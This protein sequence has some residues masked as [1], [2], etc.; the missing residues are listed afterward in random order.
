MNRVRSI[1]TQELVTNLRRRSYLLITFGVPV[2]AI[3]LV[4]AILL[5]RGDR[6]DQPDDPFA[7]LPAQPIGYVD[8]TGRFPDPGPY[9]TILVPYPD[10]AS[11][12]AAVQAGELAGYYLIPADYLATGDVTRFS[13]QFSVIETDTALFQSFLVTGL[14]RDEDP[15]LL[16]RLQQPA[17]I[18]EHQLD[19]A[20]QPVTQI[21]GR[22][23]DNFWPIYAFALVL[24][25]STFFSSGQ[26]TR[27]VVVEKENRMIEVVLS[28]LRPLQILAGKMV[29]QGIAGLI[30]VLAWLGAILLIIHIT[31]ADI[32]FLGPVDIPFS[33]FIIA[34]L[35]YLGG[36]SLFAAFAAGIGAISTNMRE[37][38]Q[39]AIVYTLPAVI[40]MM[41]LPIITESPNG[42]F[43]VVLSL[44]PF[45]SPLGMIARLVITTV[46]A[47]QIALSLALLFLGVL[48][49]LW[50]SAR[51]F[52]VNT[53][54]SGQFPT[55]RQLVQLLIRG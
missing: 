24:L 18:V 46:P 43:A 52:R 7:E 23:M 2:V 38:P 15:L 26:V 5:F 27:S 8:H 48:A 41:T 16:A 42:T 39:Y 22:G 36:Y 21:E 35:Y 17:F 4:V 37:G 14:L 9:A 19:R 1:I 51:L 3:A 13:S 32:P 12:R 31:A 29:A 47:W 50:L 10:E 20:G 34:V 30:Q 44:I 33:L 25:F 55:P 54:L 6:D 11:A 40:P 49:A 45:C 53:L 28:S